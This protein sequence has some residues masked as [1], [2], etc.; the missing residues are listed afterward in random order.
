M[1]KARHS[2]HLDFIDFVEEVL[3]GAIFKG[4][5][6]FG[7]TD[8]IRLALLDGIPVLSLFLP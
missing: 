4:V 6:P 1:Q 3:T 2:R 7:V 8:V 5:T